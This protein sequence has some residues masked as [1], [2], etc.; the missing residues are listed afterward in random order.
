MV[1][2]D[3]T[4]NAGIKSATM[5]DRWP[6]E[7]WVALESCADVCIVHFNERIVLMDSMNWPYCHNLFWTATG[8]YWTIYCYLCEVNL[9]KEQRGRTVYYSYCRD[10][11]L[12]LFI[13][14]LHKQIRT[15]R[16][17]IP[18]HFIRT[19][20]NGFGHC[21]CQKRFC[22]PNTEL[23]KNMVRLSDQERPNVDLMSA[24][25]RWMQS[26]EVMC[27]TT[28]R[29]FL[30]VILYRVWREFRLKTV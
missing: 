17:L 3:L 7:H 5:D 23:A 24:N 19:H 12:K 8:T 30:H 25:G 22:S 1:E 18:V 27:N 20:F 13:Q 21:C 14:T 11:R 6:T 26:T 16:G 10:V 28:F 4:V 15:S 2:M 9:V 29:A